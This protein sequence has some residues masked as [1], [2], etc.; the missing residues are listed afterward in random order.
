MI[1][2]TSAATRL[3]ARRM[4]NGIEEGDDD[5]NPF[6]LNPVKYNEAMEAYKTGNKN[7]WLP[8]EIQM[9]KDIEQW[10]DDDAIT[11]D[12]RRVV[13]VALGYF[14]TADS[15]VANN[16]VLAIYKHITA[17]EARMFLLRQAF[18]EAIHTTSYQY[19]VESL[20]LDEEKIFMMYKDCGEIWAKD[21]FSI[22]RTIDILNPSFKTGTFESDMKFLENLVDFYVITEGIFF[23]A[24]FAA[25]LSFRRRNLLPGTAEQFQYIT[26]DES[27]HYQFGIFMINTILKEQPELDNKEFRQNTLDKIITAAKLEEDFAKH[28][29]P[30]G[31]LSMSSD[32]FSDYTKHI[33]NLRLQ[34]INMKP[35][36]NVKN[37]YPWMAEF[38]DMSRQ[39]NFFETRVT[40]YQTG[41][42]LDMDS[43]F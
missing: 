29:M 1:I 38:L 3:A 17:P 30:R 2:K 13:E 35:A 10:K 18:E 28:M 19:I 32:T 36:F 24:T 40:E 27:A 15:I 23:Y 4:I 16:L 37:P 11:N 31:I 42:S 39:K 21:E 5:F 43:M 33:A 26:R 7:H 8:E 34:A 9:Q 41:G 22:S 12:E 20:S 6:I 25:M 14:T